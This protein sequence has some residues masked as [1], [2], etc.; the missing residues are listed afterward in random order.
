MRFNTIP[1][2]LCLIGSIFW[3]RESP[4][5]YIGRGD[6][7]K[8]FSELNFMGKMNDQFYENITI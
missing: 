2:I 8:G 1:A 4:R 7:E 3:L 6:F 5:L